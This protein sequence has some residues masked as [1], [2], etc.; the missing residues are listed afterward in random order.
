MRVGL[1]NEQKDQVS[2]L[3]WSFSRSPAVT[4]I[5]TDLAPI[6][7]RLGLVDYP[8]VIIN[9]EPKQ[10]VIDRY[11][12]LVYSMKKFLNN[13]VPGD[14]FPNNDIM[15]SRVF[16]MVYRGHTE[17]HV[18]SNFLSEPKLENPPRQM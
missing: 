11:L 7:S 5:A 10:T 6:V 17:E 9:R 1:V 2:S 4:K 15:S 13:N 12:S 14:I 18:R 8:L 16:T 3:R